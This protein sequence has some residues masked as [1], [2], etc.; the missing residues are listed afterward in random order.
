[1]AKCGYCGSTVVIG[2]ARSGDQRFCNTKCQQ[3]AH[4]LSL[5]K[6]VPPNMLE[7]QLEKVFRGNCPKCQARGPT[8][9]HKFYEVWSLLVLTRWAT[10]QQVSCRSCAVK[11]QLGALVFSLFCGWWGFPWGLILTPM[12]VVRNIVAMCSGPDPSRPSA[13]LRKLIQINLGQAIIV[14][15]QKSSGSTPPAI[16]KLR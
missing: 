11:R 16:P 14:A 4:I 15:N 9:V 6:L 2:G 10:S 12:Q 7:Q 5:S 3:N 8:D 13:A 1:M